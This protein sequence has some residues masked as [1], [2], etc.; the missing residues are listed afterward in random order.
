MWKKL[1]N[2]CKTNRITLGPFGLH[3]DGP[4]DVMNDDDN[5]DDDSRV[6]NNHTI[7]LHAMQTAMLRV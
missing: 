5:D 7:K 4:Q 2:I 3:K 6:Q 1:H